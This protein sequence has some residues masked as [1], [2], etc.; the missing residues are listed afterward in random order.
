MKL[1]S[2]TFQ[3]QSLPAKKIREAKSLIT[4]K[5]GEIIVFGG[6]QEV[7]V[8]STESKYNLLSDI[9]YFGKNS[10]AQNR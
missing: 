2:N 9:P 1:K 10:S 5:D 6:L 4:I 8:D 3:D 7:Q